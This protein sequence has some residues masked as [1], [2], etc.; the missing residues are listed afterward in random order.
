MLLERIGFV[1]IFNFIAEHRVIYDA[2]AI[3]ITGKPDT[4]ETM[5][6]D[7]FIRQWG[8]DDKVD[9]VGVFRPNGIFRVNTAD[10]EQC[11]EVLN[12][13][14]DLASSGLKRSA[15]ENNKNEVFI[16][17]NYDCMSSDCMGA[18]K[19]AY[20]AVARAYERGEKNI[21]IIL[22]SS[23]EKGELPIE[24]QGD[25]DSVLGRGVRIETPDRLSD[26]EKVNDVN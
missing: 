11:L 15:V 21:K 24:K 2:P 16:F 9:K 10:D 3:I 8:F 22:I 5:L 14:I 26:I 7:W 17:D 25:W 4:G 19:L 1:G 13:I 6:A 12:H 18:Y 23:K 20:D